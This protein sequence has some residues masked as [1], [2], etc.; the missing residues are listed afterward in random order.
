MSIPRAMPAEIWAPRRFNQV[1]VGREGS[2]QNASSIAAGFPG[3]NSVFVFCFLFFPRIELISDKSTL[4]Y[5]DS[6]K[7]LFKEVAT[8]VIFNFSKEINIFYKLSVLGKEYTFVF[9]FELYFVCM[10]ECVG[11]KYGVLI[12][13]FR[14]QIIG[15]AVKSVSR[16]P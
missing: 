5:V 11:F 16:S 15:H 6:L 12:S 8:D 4:V 14:V 13:F 2:D 1:C 3:S 10:N 9:N 7:V